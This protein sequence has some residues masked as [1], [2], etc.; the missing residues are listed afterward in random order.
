MNVLMYF[1]VWMIISMC[2]YP[3]GIGRKLNVNKTFRKFPGRILKVSPT[4]NLRPVSRGELFHDGGRY[5]TGNCGFGHIY[6]R[7][8]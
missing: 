1:L 5:Y 3:L 6:R 2:V 7:N 4:I 8:L